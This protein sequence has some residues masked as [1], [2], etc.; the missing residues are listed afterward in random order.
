MYKG[1]HIVIQFALR[2]A[3]IRMLGRE[4]GGISTL[5]TDILS[6]LSLMELGMGSAISYALYKPLAKKDSERITALMSFYKKAYTLIGIMVLCAGLICTP[7][8]QYIV[9]DVPNIKEDIRIIFIMFVL[10]SASSYF[11]VYKSILLRADQKPRIIFIVD[12]VIQ[13]CESVVEIILLLMFREYFLYLI[14]HLCA[15]LLRNIVLSQISQK[16]YAGYLTGKGKKLSREETK[17]LFKDIYAL[18]IY[19]VSGTVINSTDSI[20][21]SAFIGTIEV[22]IVGNYTLIIN[23]IRTAIEQI[24]NAVRPSV[25]NLAATSTK[26]KQELVFRQMNFVAFWVACFCSTCFFVLL[27]PFVGSIWFD[28]T[29]Q[30]SINII[31]VLTINFYIAVMVYPVEVFRTANGLFI[32]GKY[33]PALM[34]AMNIGLDLIFVRYWGIVGVLLAT[35]ISRISTQVWFD[36]YLIYKYAFGKKPWLYYLEYLENA[37]LTAVSCVLANTLA[38]LPAIENVYLA[39]LYKM[40]VAVGVSNVG[41]FLLFHNRPEFKEVK[42]RILVKLRLK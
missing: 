12:T 21:I 34:A 28:S 19:K 20:V 31:V 6:V 8:L 10:T 7:L 9:K 2:T 27:N 35:T 1:S 36:A 13:S 32:Q 33:R 11:L 29:Y 42:S 37:G 3:F 30:V 39:F 38:N 26:E 22:S 40:I 16:L 17:K 4:Y 41:L 18:A 24:V 5:F 23:S 25:G 14:L 15:T